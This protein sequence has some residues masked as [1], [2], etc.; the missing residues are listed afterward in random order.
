MVRSTMLETMWKGKKEVLEVQRKFH[1]L[2]F[3]FIEQIHRKPHTPCKA[4]IQRK[5]KAL[6]FPPFWCSWSEV[7]LGLEVGDPCV[8]LTNTALDAIQKNKH[9]QHVF[10]CL[11]MQIKML[12]CV[13]MVN[14]TCIYLYLLKWPVSVYTHYKCVYTPSDVSAKKQWCDVTGLYFLYMTH[15]QKH[16]VYKHVDDYQ[17]RI[18]YH[19]KFINIHGSKCKAMTTKMIK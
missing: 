15:W 18:L 8:N 14:T 1:L 10:N 6:F 2:C 13:D 5:H 3:L 4:Y 9:G 11:L 12:M 7:T 16:I 19:H 17:T